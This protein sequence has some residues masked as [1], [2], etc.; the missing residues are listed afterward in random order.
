MSITFACGRCG[1]VFT[2]EDKF[3]GKKGKCRQCEAVMDIPKPVPMKP[4]SSRSIGREAAPPKA[5]AAGRDV[6]PTPERP[7]RSSRAPKGDVYGFEEEPLPRH[8]SRLRGPR[9][10]KTTNRS[11]V[12]RDPTPIST[13]RRR[14]SGRGGPTIRA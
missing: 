7:S 8:A 12:D 4:A 2:V 13:H 14:K 5:P 10:T 1:K 9:R 3:G 11:R 6:A